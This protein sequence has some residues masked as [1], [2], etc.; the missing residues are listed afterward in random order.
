VPLPPG[1]GTNLGAGTDFISIH[2]WF[3]NQYG[4][5]AFPIREVTLPTIR[6]K[7]VMRE[8]LLGKLVLFLSR[9]T[10]EELAAIYRF[11]AREPLPGREL[12]TRIWRPLPDTPPAQH[13]ELKETIEDPTETGAVKMEAREEL[14]QIVDFLIPSRRFGASQARMARGELTGCLLYE[15]PAGVAWT[16]RS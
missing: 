14:E 12:D 13:P 9:A 8:S 3:V 2:L 11:A 15:P 6:V 7:T 16:V 5:P 10:P 4:K 1:A